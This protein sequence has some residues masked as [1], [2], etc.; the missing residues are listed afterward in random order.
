MLLIEEEL[1]KVKSLMLREFKTPI[2][3]GDLESFVMNGSKMI[4]SVLAILFFKAQNIGLNDNFYKILS[5]GEFV[6]NA[7][8]LHDDVL[9]DAETRRGY[10]TISKKYTPKISILAGD[11]LLSSVIENLIE[12]KDFEILDLFRNCTKTMSES[13]IKQYFL[14]GSFPSKEVYI[15]I[16]KGK[17][18]SLFSTILESCAIILDSERKISKNFGE[19]FGICFQIRNDLNKESAKIDK[20]NKIYT[21][22]DVF[23]IE[24]TNHLLDNYKEEMLNIISNFENNVYTDCLKDLVE[25]L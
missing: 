5:S 1:N 2:L 16:C 7:S 11:Y 19:L 14:R 21:A 25:K 18:A 4:R 12:I 23:G 15:D 9:D 20:Q 10:T 3:E 8:L 6:H 22:L 24:K 13:E 17:T